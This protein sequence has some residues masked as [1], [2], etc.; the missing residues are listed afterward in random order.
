MPLFDA[1][2]NELAVGQLVYDDVF[3]KNGRVDALGGD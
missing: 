2:K 3:N 1:D